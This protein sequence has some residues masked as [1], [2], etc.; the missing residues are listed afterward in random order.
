LAAAT[1]F[2]AEVICRVDVTEAILPRIS[3]K[4]AI[5]AYFFS[6]RLTTAFSKQKF[7]ANF[8]ELKRIGSLPKIRF[9]SFLIR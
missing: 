3:F 9:N 4:F 6:R 2:I 7:K 8:N 5:V 1:I